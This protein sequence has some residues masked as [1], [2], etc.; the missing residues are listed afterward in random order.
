M[1]F[2]EVIVSLFEEVINASK[3][4]QAFDQ[5]TYFYCKYQQEC[6]VA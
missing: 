3:A 2:D 6:L 4:S 5:G 1:D